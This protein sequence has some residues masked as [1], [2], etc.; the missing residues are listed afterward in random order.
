MNFAIPWPGQTILKVEDE[1]LVEY[2]VEGRKKLYIQVDIHI[3]PD[4]RTFRWE[5]FHNAHGDLWNILGSTIRRFGLTVNNNGMFIRIPDIEFHDKKKS[6]IFLTEEP[7]V[8]LAF[9]GLD[10]SKW[11]KGFDSR[12]DMFEYAARYANND[13]FFSFN[14]SHTRRIGSMLN[15]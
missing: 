1:S 10:G 12:E 8:I 15:I 2:E 9:L 13:T 5:Y 4:Y 3:C 6:M 14:H 11:F 7:A